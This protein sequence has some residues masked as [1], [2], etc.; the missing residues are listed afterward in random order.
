VGLG[1]ETDI[2]VAGV[3]FNPVIKSDIYSEL[4][5]EACILSRI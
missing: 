4:T 3:R 5:E 2:T 1:A